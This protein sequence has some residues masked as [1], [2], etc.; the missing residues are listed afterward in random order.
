MHTGIGNQASPMMEEVCTY[1]R[2]VHG[3]N[4]TGWDYPEFYGRSSLSK[5]LQL[6]K[7][8]QVG[9]SVSA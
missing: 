1:K 8:L 7:C 6:F 2:L 5:N 9:L 4:T 3:Q